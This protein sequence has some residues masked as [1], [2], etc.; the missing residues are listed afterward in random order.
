[1]LHPDLPPL[2]HPSRMAALAAYD[3]RNGQLHCFPGLQPY[4]VPLDS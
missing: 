1:M 2:H 4:G 3:L